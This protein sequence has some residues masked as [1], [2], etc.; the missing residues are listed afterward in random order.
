LRFPSFEFVSCFDI[1][2]SDFNAAS[3]R[4]KNHTVSNCHF[5]PHNL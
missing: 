1:Q 4:M 2:I 3:K 5:S